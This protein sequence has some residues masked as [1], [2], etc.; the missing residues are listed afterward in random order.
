MKTDKKGLVKAAVGF[1]AAL[2][3]SA[4]VMIAYA[5]GYRLSFNVSD[6]FPNRLYLSKKTDG[7]ELSMS[8][9]LKAGTLI[10]FRT[11]LIG[12]PYDD[13]VRNIDLLKQISCVENDY[14]ERIGDRFYCDKDEIAVAQP[15][16]GKG[17]PYA[18]SFDFNG[19]IPAGKIFVTAPHPYS[20][21][22]RYFGF[23][24]ASQITG[25]VKCVIY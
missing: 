2:C 17:R 15:L 8:D 16:D 4:P 25:V 14:L 7:A 10:L 6:S 24:D 23:I 1:G 11:R 22:S 13:R 5:A 3:L 12:T 18:I 20:F 21:D 19:T 9:N